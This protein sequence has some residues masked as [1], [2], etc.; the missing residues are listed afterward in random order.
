VKASAE[1]GFDII[2]NDKGQ[3][4]IIETIGSMKNKYEGVSSKN[5]SAIK[6]LA[7]LFNKAF[8]QEAFKSVSNLM[9]QFDSLQNNFK[10]V[11]DASINSGATMEAYNKITDTTK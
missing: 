7:D 8:G 5:Y 9:T 4:N 11:Q 2:V 6:K 3:M 10:T 1:V